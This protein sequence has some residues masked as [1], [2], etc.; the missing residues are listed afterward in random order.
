M[1]TWKQLIFNWVFKN[2]CNLYKEKDT[3]D[4]AGQEFEQK[5]EK[6]SFFKKIHIVQFG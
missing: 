5:Q 3:G 1:I 2:G 6:L 4:L